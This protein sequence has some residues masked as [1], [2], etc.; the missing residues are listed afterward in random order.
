MISFQVLLALRRPGPATEYAQPVAL[1]NS[2]GWSTG[3][4]TSSLRRR[5]VSLIMLGA[6]LLVAGGAA[7]QVARAAPAAA[8]LLLAGVVGCLAGWRVLVVARRREHSSA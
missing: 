4:G 8:G 2:T 7:L 6:F 5:G 1:R 3:A